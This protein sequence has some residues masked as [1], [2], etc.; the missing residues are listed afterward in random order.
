MEGIRA[1]KPIQ[2]IG[3]LVIGAPF[4]LSCKRTRPV[5]TPTR[6]ATVVRDTVGCNRLRPDLPDSLWSSS[7]DL[8][9][10]ITT[11]EAGQRHIAIWSHRSPTPMLAINTDL[12]NL[13]WLPGDLGLVYAVSPIYAVP[14]IYRFDPRMGTTSRVVAPKNFSDTHYRDGA[15]WFVL[16]STGATDSDSGRPIIHYLRFPHVDSLDFKAPPVGAL[17]VADTL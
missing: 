5:D 3:L 13:F 15:D 4:G 17:Q 14:G 12:V 2:L 16:C 10:R 6:A 9:A 8:L 11:A 1:L 7:G